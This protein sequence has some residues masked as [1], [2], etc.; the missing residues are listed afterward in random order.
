MHIYEHT[1][2]IQAHVPKRHYSYGTHVCTY[3]CVYM[4]TCIFIS[5]RVQR[6]W[7]THK[8]SQMYH[9]ALPVASQKLGFGML[10]GPSFACLYKA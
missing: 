9:F 8:L 7:G 10:H 1:V 2:Y 4:C 5:Y 6:N 3:T